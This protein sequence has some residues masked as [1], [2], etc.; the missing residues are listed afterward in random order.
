M[1]KSSF[2]LQAL[3]FL[4]IDWNL[5]TPGISAWG[6]KHLDGYISRIKLPFGSWAPSFRFFGGQYL[7]LGLS[8]NDGTDA[9][10]MV[11][12]HFLYHLIVGG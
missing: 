12:H 6:R 11:D 3:G 10:I 7:G 9:F 5:G 8:E 4:W 1:D 2:G